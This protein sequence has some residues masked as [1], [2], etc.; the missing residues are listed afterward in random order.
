MNNEINLDYEHINFAVFKRTSCTACGF[1]SNYIVFLGCLRNSLIDG[2]VPIIESES[3]AN[4]M[5]GFI[6]DPLKG[7]PWEYYFN[8]PFGYKY[9]NIKAKAKNI[10]YIE[11]KPKLWPTEDIFLNRNSMNYWHF[12]ANQYIPIK[13]EIIIEANNLLNRIFKKSRNILGVL[14]RGTDYVANKPPGHP[15]P[16]KTED[17]IKD[18]K[19]LDIKNKYDWI[20]LATEDNIIRHNFIKGIGNK[21]KCLLNKRKIFYNYSEKKFLVYSID[22]KKN[23]DFNKIYLLNIII[24]SKCLDLLA[25]N[26]SG[27][28]GIFILTKGFRNYKVYNLG[29]YK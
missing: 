7:N 14:L 3:Y 27:T 16:P 6:I 13:N 2:F 24:L 28:I 20:F 1:F 21:V 17:A 11:C 10:K 18:V 8:Q 22:Y 9:S 12:L 25:A 5:N 23:S 29:Y 19:L 4:I 15:I 26:T